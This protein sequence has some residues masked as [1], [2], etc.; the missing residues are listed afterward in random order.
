MTVAELIVALQEFAPDVE[1]FVED[2]ERYRTPS[3]MDERANGTLMVI[4]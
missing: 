2:D 3:V 1:V 4:L